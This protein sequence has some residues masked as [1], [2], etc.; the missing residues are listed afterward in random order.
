MLLMD[1][2]YLCLNRWRE[3]DRRSD[4]C[5]V[6]IT[7]IFQADD[8][9]R[10]RQQLFHHNHGYAHDQTAKWSDMEAWRGNEISIEPLSMTIQ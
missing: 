5:V 9:N 7:D 3:N 2:Y 6:I 8:F 4:G 10:S 1:A